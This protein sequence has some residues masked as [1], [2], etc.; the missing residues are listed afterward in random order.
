[1]CL[2]IVSLVFLSQQGV[3]YA[4]TTQS[5]QHRADISYFSGSTRVPQYQPS[6]AVQA[7]GSRLTVSQNSAKKGIPKGR[8]S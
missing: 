3:I 6:N 5:R 7:Y 1:M 2:I 8:F 4:K